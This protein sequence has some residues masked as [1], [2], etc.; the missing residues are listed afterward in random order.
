MQTFLCYAKDFAFWLTAKYF[1]AVLEFEHR[2]SDLQGRKELHHL[3]YGPKPFCF[4]FQIEFHV[5]CP[6][7]P[8]QWSSYL[9]LL[10]SWNDWLIPH[11]QL[12]CQNKILLTFCLCW[13]QTSIFSISNSK[14][15]EITSMRLHNQ[16]GK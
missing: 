9:C 4:I 7:Q 3:R 14:V 1:F 10:C 15:A 13:P 2:D 6:G 12:I 11:T 16:Q 8:G 5:F